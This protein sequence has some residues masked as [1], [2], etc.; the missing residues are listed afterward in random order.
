VINKFKLKMTG[1]SG[2]IG[3]SADF[4]KAA[5]C[6]FQYSQKYMQRVAIM[7]ANPRKV[8]VTAGQ[9][10]FD[11]NPALIFSK[12]KA[13]SS[14][15]STLGNMPDTDCG[16]TMYP[17]EVL[18][19]TRSS[20]AA[21]LNWKKITP[22]QLSVFQHLLRME[23]QYLAGCTVEWERPAATSDAEDRSEAAAGQSQDSLSII[24][25]SEPQ[26]RAQGA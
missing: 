1:A 6:Y 25:A 26:G 4:Q 13:V 5:A 7:K 19:E 11:F 16:L 24:G 2:N 15:L 21:A 18:Y 9:D 3:D 12:D 10:I 8:P 17:F 14:L 22:E 20:A 23:M